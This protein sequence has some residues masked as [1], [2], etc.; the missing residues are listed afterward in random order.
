AAL[1]NGADALGYALGVI[2][3]TAL[4]HAVG[5][6]AAVLLQNDRARTSLRVGGVGMTLA[7]A[8]WAFGVV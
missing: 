7:G 5:F 6:F 3:S 2:S 1:S 4:L 8:A